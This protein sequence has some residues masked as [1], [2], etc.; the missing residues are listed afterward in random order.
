MR[1]WTRYQLLSTLFFIHFF[2]SFSFDFIMIYHNQWPYCSCNFKCLPINS[3]FIW[4]VPECE[5]ASARSYRCRASTQHTTY[6][7]IIYRSMN[8]MIWRYRRILVNAS[9]DT[10]TFHKRSKM[11]ASTPT[12]LHIPLYFLF[13]MNT[14]PMLMMLMLYF[15]N[16]NSM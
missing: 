14:I 12:R 6:A 9:L 13:E 7:I 11:S 8:G 5:C 10:W 2:F 3:Q 16:N 1:Q 15:N 4:T